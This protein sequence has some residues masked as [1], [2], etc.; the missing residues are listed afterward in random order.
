MKLGRI[1]IFSVENKVTDNQK[2]KNRNDATH[3]GDLIGLPPKLANHIF[4]CIDI[5]SIQKIKFLQVKG[6]FIKKSP[7]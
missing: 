5:Y 6:G 2:N 4:N 3:F 7:F 1:S